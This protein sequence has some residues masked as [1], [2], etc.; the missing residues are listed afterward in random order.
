MKILFCD[1]SLKE[2]LNFRGDIIKHFANNN[3]IVLIAPNNLQDRSLLGNLK[4]YSVDI[5]RSGMNPLTEFRYFL[6]LLTLYKR[7][8]PDLVFH[9]TIKPNV[10]GGFACKLCRIPSVA[11]I[12][13]LGYAFNHNDLKSKI[14]RTMY[15]YALNFANKVFVLNKSIFNFLI[16]QKLVPREKLKFLE[17]GEG[18]N[19]EFFK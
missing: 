19:L 11:M 9:Y 14:A 8:K 18:I 10:Y 12:T 4:V 17:G 5:S 13:G 2:L 16:D 7:E 3:D 15:K 1:N 6:K